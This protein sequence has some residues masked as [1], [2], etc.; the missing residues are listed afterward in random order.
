MVAKIEI[1]LRITLHI[2]KNPHT[3]RAKQTKN[4]NNRIAALQRIKIKARGGRRIKRA[5][6]SPKMAYL[7]LKIYN[8]MF[9]II[10]IFFTT[11][12]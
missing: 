11:D 1:T 3:L 2:T 5:N 8:F 4:N 12:L 10:H 7:Y 9:E 6:N